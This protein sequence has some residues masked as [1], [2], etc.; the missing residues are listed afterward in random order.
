MKMTMMM[1]MSVMI[2][3]SNQQPL[4]YRDA[5]NSGLGVHST[6][7]SSAPSTPIT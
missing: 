6:C 3:T 4:I 1:M 5:W 7:L 2:S